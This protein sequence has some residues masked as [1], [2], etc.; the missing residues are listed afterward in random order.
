MLIFLDDTD[1]TVQD[2]ID[3]LESYDR[4]FA[5]TIAQSD[6][7]KKVIKSIKEQL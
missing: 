3:A 4:D 1:G 2:V 6:R 5:E 7:I